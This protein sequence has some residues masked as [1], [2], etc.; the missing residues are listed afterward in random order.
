MGAYAA[1]TERIICLIT[2]EQQLPWHKPFRV[3]AP[4]NT[5][6]K[7]PYR[8]INRLVLSTAGFSDPRFLTFKQALDLGGHVR[9]GE[10]GLPVVFWKFERDADSEDRKN[11]VVCRSFTVFNVEQCNDL[12]VPEFEAPQ[13]NPDAIKATHDLVDAYKNG[14]RIKWGFDRACYSPKEDLVWMPKQEAFESSESCFGTLAHELTHSTMHESRLNRKPAAP[15]KFG[16][17]DYSAEELVAELGA[18]FLCGDFGIHTQVTQS[19]AYV[20]GWLRALKN[21]RSMIIRAAARAEKAADWI[22]GHREEIEQLAETEA[23]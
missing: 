19:A 8:G 9:K 23:A 11:S 13:V 3:M 17:E 5:I 18:A 22:L 16:S 2:S 4:I 6:S 20:K 15:V 12:D 14:P 1:I 21:D 7:K 10:K